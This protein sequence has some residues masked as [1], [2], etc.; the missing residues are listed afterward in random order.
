MRNLALIKEETRPAHND[1]VLPNLNV[2]SYSR[3]LDDRVRAYVDMI[4]YFHGIVVEV[5]PIGFVRWSR[6]GPL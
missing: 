2:T 3:R 6:L 5:S 4:T 1:A